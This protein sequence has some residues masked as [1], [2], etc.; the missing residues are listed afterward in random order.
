LATFD[1]YGTDRDS[2]FKREM[3]CTTNFIFKLVR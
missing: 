2:T 1:A 3:L